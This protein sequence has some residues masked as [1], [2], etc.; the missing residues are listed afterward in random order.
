[1]TRHRQRLKR[2]VVSHHLVLLLVLLLLQY[3]T[4]KVP[5]PPSSSSSSS[6]T[7]NQALVRS[8][9]QAATVPQ[10]AL[11]T[12][13]SSLSTPLAASSSSS[14]SVSILQVLETEVY[15]GSEW[16]GAYPSRWTSPETNR[17]SAPP[18]SLEPPRGHVFEGSWKIVTSTTSRDAL[19]W[20]YHWTKDQPAQ[21]TRTWLRTVVPKQQQSMVRPPTARERQ[22]L[23]PTSNNLP[24]ILTRTTS[25]VVQSLQDHWNFKGYGLTFYK[26]LLFWKSFGMAFRIPLL[27]NFDWW[28][29]HPELP[30]VTS[31]IGLYFPFMLV[32]FLNASVNID[33]LQWMSW[34]VLRYIHVLLRALVVY[35][36]HALTLPVLF[37]LAPHRKTLERP[38]WIPSKIPPLPNDPPVYSLVLSQRLGVSLSWRYSKQRGYEFR[39][40]QWF[41]YVPTIV[42]LTEVLHRQVQKI[43]LPSS[44]SST[45]QQQQQQQPQP[46]QQANNN[47]DEQQQESTTVDNRLLQWLRQKTGSL[48][49]SVGRPTPDAPHFS[50]SGLL[51]LSGFHL[52]K[53]NP[54]QQ[55]QERRRR[56]QRRRLAEQQQQQSRLS[57]SSSSSS[58]TKASAAQRDSASTAAA[59]AVATEATTKDDAKK[60][61]VAS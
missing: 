50:C 10:P 42:Y 44:S 15:D 54:L 61:K 21:R 60:K 38:S 16:R 52:V 49:L 47:S 19:G 2:M 57:S 58:S 26:S 59:A 20:E 31:S 8:R 33:W 34:R 24:P 46:Q 22:R 45:S 35:T 3:S 4:A 12:S 13:S 27:S 41:V 5:N 43:L 1:M 32:G 17:E 18:P 39:L 29:R 37:L 9:N 40:S 51:S 53:R 56:Q 36:L 14:S 55:Q 25:A 7:N 28:D 48:G 6:S 23:F 11:P 30:S